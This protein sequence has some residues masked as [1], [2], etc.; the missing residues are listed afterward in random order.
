[1]VSIKQLRQ[2]IENAPLFVA[3][4]SH[5]QVNSVVI[6]IPL[7]ALTGPVIVVVSSLFTLIISLDEVNPLCQHKRSVSLQRQAGRVRMA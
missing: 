1:M 2:G 3:C 6:D 7:L 4:L 5:G